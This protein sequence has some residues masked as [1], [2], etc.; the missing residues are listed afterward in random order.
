M[1][2]LKISKELLSEVLGYEVDVF[3]GVTENE[4][5]YTCCRDKNVGYEDISI[6]IY[7]FAFKCKEWAYENDYYVYSAPSFA[8]EGVAYIVEDNNTGKRLK[9]LQLDS[10]VEAI[11]QACGWILNQ[12]GKK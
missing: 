4:I 12:E 7:E 9:T 6:N 3:L 11:I 1:K 5:D 10:E 8:L 2:D